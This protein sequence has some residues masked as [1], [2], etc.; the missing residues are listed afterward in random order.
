LSI[1]VTVKAQVIELPLL[2]RAVPITVVTPTGNAK[3]LAGTLV[4]FVTRQLSVAV[5]LKVRLLKH[6]PGAAF[7]VRF[8]GQVICGGWVSLTVTAKLHVALLPCASVAVLVTVVV[9][10]AKLLPLA[11]TLTTL[12]PGQLSVAVTTKVTLLEQVPAAA[13]TTRL[14][15]Q[16]IRGNRVSFTVTMKVHVLELPLPSRAVLVTV[17][18]PSGK[19]NPLAGLLVMLVTAQLSVAFTMK[20]TLLAHTPGAALT[21]IFPGQ[22]IAGG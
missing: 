17:V 4:T 7:T 3:P 15:E 5:T 6:R 8:A 14:L 21:V 12:T 2:S 11:G 16:V 13:F 18:E 9:P 19:A 22:L 20:V 10:T 1:T